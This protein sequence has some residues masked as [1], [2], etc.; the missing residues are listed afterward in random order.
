MH[1]VIIRRS[2]ISTEEGPA[3]PH[4]LMGLCKLDPRVDENF[5]YLAQFTLRTDAHPACDGNFPGTDSSGRREVPRKRN[6][7]GRFHPSGAADN[8]PG[9]SVYTACSVF[10]GIF[11]AGG[12]SMPRQQLA[13]LISDAPLALAY[14]KSCIL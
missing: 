5:F 14:R 10:S 13:V 9:V 11:S 1:V 6:G 2:L 8:H 12:E 3:D 4:M 7:A